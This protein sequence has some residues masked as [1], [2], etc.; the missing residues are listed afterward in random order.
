MESRAL[1]CL[2][3]LAVGNVLGLVT[4]SCSREQARGLLGGDGPLLSLPI[5]ERQRVWDDDLAMAMALAG[6]LARLPPEA[7]R[8]DTREI[9]EAYL[10]W[11]RSGARGIGG[12]TRE[13]LTKTL[14]GEARASE[15]VWQSRCE[16]G[17]RPLGNGAT[18]RIAPLGVAFAC[19]PQR[20]ADLAAEDASLTHWDPACRQSAGAVAL[21]AAALVRQ[22]PDPLAFTRRYLG[23]LEAEVAE[24][25]HPLDLVKVHEEGL[26]GWD[27]GSTLL[28]LKVAVSVL[29]SGLP[30]A[31]GVLWTLRQ[32][33]DTDTH[34]AIVGAL[35]GARDGLAA[36][37]LD[38]RSCVPDGDR[39][40][41]MAWALWRRCG[42]PTPEVN[43]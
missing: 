24:A 2:A 41:R 5:E 12:L 22:E 9:L 14:A 20:I 35:L 28:A 21:L 32:G 40:L 17:A 10:E 4:E 39:I 8:L 37:P 3:G 30:Y 36:I 16:R 25:L 15:W 38:W 1:G 11:F 26:D 13:V 34:G 29:A 27:M 23:P 6:C 7:S 42:V 19:S 18:M 43:P 33:G 31:E